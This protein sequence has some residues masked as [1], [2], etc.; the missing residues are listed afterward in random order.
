MAGIS[1][2]LVEDVL[3]RVMRESYSA[4]GKTGFKP[5]NPELGPIVI[6][7]GRGMMGS[8]FATMFEASSYDV[9]SLEKDDWNR[10][11]DVLS[12]AGMVSGQRTYF[13]DT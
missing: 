11:D 6:V 9:V 13:T 12:R 3:R 1:P 8:M 10:S 2:D 5:T 4:E 7:G